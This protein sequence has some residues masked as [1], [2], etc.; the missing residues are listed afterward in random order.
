MKKIIIALLLF[1]IF[2]IAQ[3]DLLAGFDTPAVNQK[4]ESA[5][6]A[7]K[8]VNLEST[9]IAAKGD[10]YF[11]VAH[12]FASIK[13]GVEGGF[14]LDN[15]NTQIKFIKG[16]ATGLSISAARSELAYDFGLK[17]MLKSQIENGRSKSTRLNSSHERRSRMPSSA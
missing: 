6:K 4:V 13:S 14:G 2:S 7:L 17:Y 1:P 8:I 11:I 9:K 10:F 3:D 12:R 5:F 16:L 15:A